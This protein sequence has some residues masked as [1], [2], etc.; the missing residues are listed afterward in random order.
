[1]ELAR[2]V[3]LIDDNSDLTLT[4]R[5]FLSLSGHLVYDAETARD[6]LSLIAQVRPDVV[7]SDIDLPDRDGFE[8]AQLVK[9]DPELRR[10]PLIAVTARAELATSAPDDHCFDRILIKPVP[11]ATILGIV[12]ESPCQPN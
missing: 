3:V 4:V 8:L 9:Q 1:M 10:I 12:Q 6:G 7:F 2:K 5:L 11:L